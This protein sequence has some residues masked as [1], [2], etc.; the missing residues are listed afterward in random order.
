MKHFLRTRTINVIAFC[1][2][3]QAICWIFG[4]V[5]PVYEALKSYRLLTV[6]A[7]ATYFVISYICYDVVILPQ[8]KKYDERLKNASIRVPRKT[9]KQ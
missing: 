4:I 3:I 8:R 1:A 2:A 7:V 9:R 5:D 6:L